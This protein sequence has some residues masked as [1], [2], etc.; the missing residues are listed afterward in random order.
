MS[1]EAIIIKKMC[2]A[3]SKT[4]KLAIYSL[5][6]T[7]YAT[8]FNIQQFYV[9]PAQCI[10][11]FRVDLGVNSDYFPFQ[12]I[13]WLLFI[14]KT[15]CVYCAVRS[16]FYVLPTQRIYV[17]CVHLKTNSDY[18]PFTSLTDWFL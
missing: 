4:P 14:T 18:F 8:R 17:F 7:T 13:N 11:V 1:L 3:D 15:G 10:Y 16:T 2:N 5:A 9:L 12:I 6:V